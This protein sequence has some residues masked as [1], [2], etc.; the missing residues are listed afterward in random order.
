M[1]LYEIIERCIEEM[2]KHFLPRL[3]KPKTEE[4]SS[5]DAIFPF[6]D[7]K[8]MRTRIVSH[9]ELVRELQLVYWINGERMEKS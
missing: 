5:W 6:C 3:I 1:L 9:Q 8:K 4:N 7:K 2:H